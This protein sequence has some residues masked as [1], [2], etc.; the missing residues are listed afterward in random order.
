MCKLLIIRWIN[1]FIFL[2]FLWFVPGLGTEAEKV[3][4]L[5]P[6]F[7]STPR[8]SLV[9]WAQR[10]I[11]SNRNLH[12]LLRVIF[13]EVLM[14]YFEISCWHDDFMKNTTWNVQI[15]RVE[16]WFHMVLLMRKWFRTFLCMANLFI[17]T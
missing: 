17:S 12:K 14:E 9:C 7:F 2:W 1:S 10:P 3:E 6:L 11:P 15:T 8:N 13:P 4:I 5:S 16:L